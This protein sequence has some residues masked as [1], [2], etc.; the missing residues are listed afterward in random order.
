MTRF[1]GARAAALVDTE[2]LAE[3]YRTLSAHAASRASGKPPRIIAVVKANAY[4]HGV[5]LAARAFARCGCDFFAVATAD[6]AL[7]LKKITPSADILVLGYTPPHRVPTLAKQGITQTVFSPEY[8]TALSRVCLAASVTL[9][10]HIKLDCGMA[11][12]GFPPRASEALLKALT[13][14]GLR[15]TGLYTHFPVADS[16]TAATLAARE[17]FLSCRAALAAQGFSLFSHAAAS[18]ALLTLPSL[19]LD[20]VRPG[21]ALYGIAPTKTDLPLRPALSLRAPV[22]QIHSLPK[23]AP[24]GY[25]GDFVTA[26]KA[27]IGTV[28]L[29]YADGI[30]RAF[31]HKTVRVFH[32]DTPFFAPIVGRIC[33]DQLML[34]LSDTPC[35]VGDAVHFFEDIAADAAAVGTIPYE[36]LTAIGPRIT[37]KELCP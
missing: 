8:A 3:N 6:E 15:P 22:V 1:H 29:G 5:R 33:M 24:V 4:G 19:C 23:G 32:G 7:A 9:A 31:S 16:D 17:R 14:D 18:A 13:L 35:E 12:L 21:L 34:D 37:R 27:R 36:L 25:G 11:R 26:R 30:F 10:V 2:A 20:G 28:P